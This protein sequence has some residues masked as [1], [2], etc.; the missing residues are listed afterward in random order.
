[1]LTGIGVGSRVRR[2]WDWL[3]SYGDQDGGANSLGT[4]IELRRWKAAYNTSAVSSIA[5]VR[6]FWD[7]GGRINTYRWAADE[8]GPRDLEVVGWRQLTSE[9]MAVQ[10][11]HEEKAAYFKSQLASSDTTVLLLS[12]Y[13]QLGGDGWKSAKGWKE[14][15]AALASSRAEVA[16]ANLNPCTSGWEGVA[17]HDGKVIGLD[18]SNNNLK[19]AP[20][21]VALPEELWILASR[22][23]RSINLSH[24]DFRGVVLSSSASSTAM[25]SLCKASQLQFL[26]LSA[27]GLLGQLPPCLSNLKELQ[28][29]F[30][31]SNNLSGEIPDAWGSR[32]AFR[33][34]RALQLHN[35]PGLEGQVPKPLL[36][37]KLLKSITLPQHMRH[38]L[39]ELS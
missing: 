5:G 39:Y 19:L 16:N 3:D 37:S 34:L 12:I 24:N 11:R 6:V 15:A 30:L 28:T 18:L 27:A 4:V 29:L 2:G 20:G 8:V 21:V 25:A 10:S 1:M 23:I 9:M 17:C 22:G 13:R 32:D 31:H 35:N 38:Q 7:V 14:A 26:D 36:Q 33:S